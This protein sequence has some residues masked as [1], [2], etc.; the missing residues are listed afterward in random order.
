MLCRLFIA[1]LCVGW[2]FT[3]DREARGADTP[4]TS[5][6]T[7]QIPQ[8]TGGTNHLAVDAR[9]HR[10]FVTAPGDK[11][12]VVVDLKA[13]QVRK[14]IEGV[15]AAAAI[16][17]PNLDQLCVSG[18]GGV[19][20]YEGDS[21]APLGKVDLHAA[22]D[23]L[24][25]DARSKR[26]YAGV[27]DANDPGIAVIDAAAR[28]LL[29]KIK[30]PAK[31]QG[32]V[33]EE[34]GPLIYANTPAAAQVTV[35]DRDHGTIVAE[36]KLPKAQGNYPIAL[37]ESSRRILV[38]CR[39]PAEVLVLDTTS[40][41]PV[42]SVESGSDADDMSFDSKT[43]RAYLACGEGLISTVRHVAGDRY[44]RLADTPTADGARNSLFVPE[45][46]TLYV[47]IPKQVNGPAELRAYRG[48]E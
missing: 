16:F 28:K 42:A 46:N 10:F 6:Q 43:G 5:V 44:E 47:A 26:V 12:V 38:G 8:L 40:G 23:E 13:G 1:G 33:I 22:I 2:S 11:K 20:F 31:P 48:R 3:L 21:L 32:F 25:Y 17:L 35:L 4:L 36:W 7:I 45:L 27:M 24:Q 18:G 37:D 14:V 29:K 34:H 19:A 39:R 41:K 15:P 30:L 9:R